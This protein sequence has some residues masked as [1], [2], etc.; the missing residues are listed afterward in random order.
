MRPF[1]LL[2]DTKNENALD[3]YLDVV[4]MRYGMKQ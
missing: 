1:F 3:M 4:S 2:S